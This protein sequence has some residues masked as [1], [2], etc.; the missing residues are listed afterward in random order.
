MIETAKT[1]RVNPLDA[2]MTKA[3]VVRR[4]FKSALPRTIKNEIL[5]P[6]SAIAKALEL[7]ERFRSE[8]AAVPGLSKSDVSAGLVYVR[9]ETPGLEH[10][11][12]TALIPDPDKGNIGMFVE[13]TMALDKPLFLG[14]IFIQ[15]DHEAT[16][17]EQRHVIFVWPF[18]GGPEAEKRLKAARNQQ[19]KARGDYRA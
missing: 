12:G 19:A 8:M 15:T 5:A 10:E 9:P 11:T 4:R 1:G 14:V 16:K 2:S 13:T 7:Y 17:P 6:M 18:M 3:Q